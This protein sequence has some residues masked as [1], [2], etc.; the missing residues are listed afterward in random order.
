MGQQRA[1]LPAD[2][3]WQPPLTPAAEVPAH[4]FHQELDPINEQNE[5]DQQVIHQQKELE[6]ENQFV[7]KQEENSSNSSSEFS[8]FDQESEQTSKST[9][10][11]ENDLNKSKNETDSEE[12]ISTK[13]T[14][15]PTDT[16]IH[17]RRSCENSS[18][19]RNDGITRKSSRS[20]KQRQMLNI[21]SFGK[22]ATS[23]YQDNSNN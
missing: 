3:H 23:Y 11:T 21:Q 5:Q 15:S 20:V 13:V 6:L 12:P 7:G 22:A 9:D 8:L 14:N 19:V 4:P 10:S 2:W 18:F 17:K 1:G 16:L